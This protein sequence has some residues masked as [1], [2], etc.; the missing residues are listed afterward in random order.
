[1]RQ[2]D[3]RM[4][5][6]AILIALLIEQA[7][8]LTPANLV[9]T[10]YRAWTVSVRR[11]FDAGQAHHGWLAWTVAVA[12]PCVLVT[13][14]YLLLLWGVGWPLA[15]V[16]NV[17]VLY[18]TLGFR[19][20]SHHFT[21]IRDALDAGDEYAAREALA[22]WQQVDASEVPRSEVVR[23]VIEYSVLAA[24]RH[25][26][27]VL[28][29]FSALAALGLGPLGAVFYRMTEHLSRS[30][31]RKGLVGGTQVSPQLQHTSR[32]AWTVIDWLPARLTALSFAV[33][34]SFE[35][36]IE[37]WR[38]HAQ[39]FPNDNDGV[40]L[41]ATSGAIN[42][43]L[44]GEALKRR[45]GISVTRDDGEEIDLDVDSEATPGREPE[46]GHLRSVVGLVWRSVVVW[47][48][49]LALLSLARLLG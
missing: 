8:P 11:N 30:W 48:L 39:R 24:H 38:F 33:V 6:F 7:R 46:I 13:G 49:L 43:R 16:W 9:H 18:V 21:R 45:E 35:E 37:G 14:I 28:F 42:V 20:F 26:F 29:W 41:A 34:G 1:M 15:M 40:I 2:Y 31:S 3:G 22:H 23:H 47:L 36:A 27:G 19:Q 12:L 17:A 25:V 5:F 32:L 4:S 10:G 44:G